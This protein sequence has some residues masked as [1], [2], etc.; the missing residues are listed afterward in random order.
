M[1]E[2]RKYNTDTLFIFPLIEDGDADFATD[3]TP[4]IGD[5]KIWTD[6]L[7]STTLSAETVAFT[8]GGT[9]VMI[10]GD[11]ITGATSSQTATVVAVVTTSGTWSGGDAAG[12]LFVKSA[13]GAFQSENLNT[14]GQANNCTIGGDLDGALQPVIIGNGLMAAAATAA[15]MSCEQGSIHIVDSATKAIEDQAILFTTFGNASALHAF[16]LDTALQT[17][18]LTHVMGTILAEGAGGRLAAAFNKLFDVVTPTLVASDV[19]RGTDGVDTS[20]M[21]GTDS[22]VLSGPTRAQMDT[23]HALLATPAQVNTEVDNAFTTQVADSVPSDGTRATREQALYM[24]LQSLTE[25]SISG[26]TITVKKVDGS[27][28]LMTFTLDDATNPTSRT[29][30]T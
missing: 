7:I 26:T 4:A 3:Y 30:A 20:T 8:G 24:I 15:E 9:R 22:V 6:T 23:A 12:F 27:T 19:M 21:R 18:D 28:T 5:A 16:D 25:F 1:S 29:R 17:V 14:G 2:R 13:S 11:T 10:R